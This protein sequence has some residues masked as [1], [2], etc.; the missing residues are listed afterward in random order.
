MGSQLPYGQKALHIERAGE[1]KIKAFGKMSLK[2]SRIC[3]VHKGAHQEDK[4]VDESRIPEKPGRLAWRMWT[5]D[6]GK[7]MR[8]VWLC[9]LCRKEIDWKDTW[10][11]RTSGDITYYT[12]HDLCAECRAKNIPR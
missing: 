8:S 7:K 9:G 2:K 6:C 12:N 11:Q 10:A 5:C 4:L 1:P 3:K